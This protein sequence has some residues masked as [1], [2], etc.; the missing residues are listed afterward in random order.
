VGGRFT[1][2]DQA[3]TLVRILFHLLQEYARHLGQLDVVVELA[4]GTTGE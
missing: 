4:T 1:S 3:P 2:P